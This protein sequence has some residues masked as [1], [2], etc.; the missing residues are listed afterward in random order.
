M[1]GFF[2]EAFMLEVEDKVFW[3][4]RDLWTGHELVYLSFGIEPIS[5]EL[6]Q[7]IIKQFDKLYPEK[8]LSDKYQA[9]IDK[10]EDIISIYYKIKEHAKSLPNKA[11]QDTYTCWYHDDC[12]EK[13]GGVAYE[14]KFLVNWLQERG[15]IM[16][17]WINPKKSIYQQQRECTKVESKTPDFDSS[18][19]MMNGWFNTNICEAVKLVALTEA[20]AHVY[21]KN[22]ERNKKNLSSGEIKDFILKHYDV[23]DTNGSIEEEGRAERFA[24]SVSEIA[25]HKQLGSSLK[26]KA[27]N[28]K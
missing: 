21:M 5:F 19:I 22:K 12:E 9:C 7:E 13:F 25:T 6:H 11:T 23:V 2:N 8:P 4:S 16:P 20:Y 1:S 14:S 10:F 24:K 3:N 28:K 27:A 26:K 18:Q 15:Y 17:A